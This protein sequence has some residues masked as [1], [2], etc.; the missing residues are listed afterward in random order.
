M[1]AELGCNDPPWTSHVAAAQESQEAV[2]GV[3]AESISGGFCRAL[4]AFS[5]TK[6]E[7]TPGL[8]SEGKTGLEQQL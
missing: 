2:A 8:L 1:T 5:Q 6:P 7:V 3:R 4:A